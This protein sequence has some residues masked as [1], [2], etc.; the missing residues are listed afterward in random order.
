MP[1]A[2]VVRQHF[3]ETLDAVQSKRRIPISR[4]G[5]VVAYIISKDEAEVFDALEDASDAALAEVALKRSK[6]QSRIV[7]RGD[8]QAFLKGA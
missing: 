1:S 2:S 7:V 6:G 8:V 3:S 5:C 4:N